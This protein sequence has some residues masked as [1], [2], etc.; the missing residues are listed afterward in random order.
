[1]IFAGLLGAQGRGFGGGGSLTPPTP[2]QTIQNE[3]NRLTRFFNLTS[4][5]VTEVTKILTTEQACLQ[6]D[7]TNLQTAR[8]ALVTAIKAGNSG[9]ISAAIATLTSL[10]AAQETCRATAEA[11]IYA[12]LTPTQQALVGSGLGPLGGG[13]G[14]PRAR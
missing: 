9:N 1:M 6:G 13:G 5:Q 3:V 7:S 11:A 8:E 10:Q 14:Q 2:A 12:D 4:S